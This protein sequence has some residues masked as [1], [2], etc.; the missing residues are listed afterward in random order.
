MLPND[1]PPW[2]AVQHPARRWVCA[3]CFAALMAGRRLLL[4]LAVGRN[5][6]PS[7]A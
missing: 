6:A 4:R 3:G 2:H 7:A 1:L 5:D